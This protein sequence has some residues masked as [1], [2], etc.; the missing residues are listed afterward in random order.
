MITF[1]HRYKVIIMYG[2]T[3]NMGRLT[4][5]LVRKTPF[6]DT[7]IKHNSDIIMNEEE[8]KICK[9]RDRYQ[10]RYHF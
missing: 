9:L 5:H 1:L 4:L 7:E 2:K 8:P 6:H 10:N 3:I